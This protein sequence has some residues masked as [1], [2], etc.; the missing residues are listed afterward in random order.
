MRVRPDNRRD[1]L[2]E[3]PATAALRQ[4]TARIP[5]RA[6]E[7]SLDLPCHRRQ[8][9]RKPHRCA[10]HRQICPR[11][12][13]SPLHCSQ[14]SL[15][16]RSATAISPCI[17]PAAFCASA[18]RTLSSSLRRRVAGRC[19]QEQSCQE[20][21]LPPLA[22]QDTAPVCRGRTVPSA[23]SSP[24][25]A[26]RIPPSA[27]TFRR[28]LSTT[29]R[30]SDRAFRESLGD[31]EH[32][33]IRPGHPF[34]DRQGPSVR[35]TDAKI[36]P[37]DDGRREISSTRMPKHRWMRYWMVNGT[38]CQ[39][40][41]WRYIARNDRDRCLYSGAQPAGVDRLVALGEV[42]LNIFLSSFFSAGANAEQR[43]S[44]PAVCALAMKVLSSRPI[45]VLRS[46]HL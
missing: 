6:F 46:V 1:T 37:D 9:I 18:V 44:R 24:V 5:T 38:G 33:V 29:L 43:D 23:G 28:K 34:P 4:E 25:V 13:L 15:S 39:W 2:H 27:V 14:T 19:L 22:L 36:D 31:R 42:E 26:C 30:N 35:P 21:L 11:I 12:Q 10:S 41:L 20:Q 8:P 7:S 17:V 40:A 32:P 3:M 16:P 45:P